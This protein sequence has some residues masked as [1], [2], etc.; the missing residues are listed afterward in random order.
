LFSQANNITRNVFNNA[1]GSLRLWLIFGAEKVL[2]KDNLAFLH[3]PKHQALRKSLLPLFTKKALALYLEVQQVKIHEHL[4]SWVSHTAD[5]AKMIRICARDMNIETS[6]QVFV[7]T[8]LNDAE[9]QIFNE[10]YF[11]INDGLLAF[12][13]AFPGSTLW[14]AIRAKGKL[15]KILIGVVEKSKARIAAGE[16]PTCLLDYWIV[17]YLKDPNPALETDEEIAYLVLDFLF[18]SQDASTSSIVWSVQLLADHPEVLRRVRE[19]QAVLRPNNETITAD[20]IA[21]M[22]YTH[23][24]VKEVLRFRPP[25]TMVPHIAIEDWKVDDEEGSYVVKKGSVILPSIWCSSFQGYSNPYEFDPDR[26]NDERMEHIKYAKSWLVFGAGPHLCLG[27][28]YAMNHLT[29]FIA[30]LASEYDWTHKRT[31]KSENIIFLPTIF[32][33]DGCV[34]QI[35]PRA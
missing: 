6:Q 9:H 4:E 21:K 5:G 16:E 15:I 20:L 25:A 24:V 34:M 28:E 17:E 32:P 10:L 26:F 2:G 13:V 29:A 12:P 14:K 11:T 7:G 8:Y 19:E 31:D 22:P 1:K 33:E 30:I 3:G 18:A 27:K 35:K 23:Q